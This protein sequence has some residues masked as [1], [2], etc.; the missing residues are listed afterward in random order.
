[1]P[2]LKWCLCTNWNH[3]R[4]M[5][6]GSAIVAEWNVIV[7][8]SPATLKDRVSFHPSESQSPLF[9]KVKNPWLN[10]SQFCSL[11]EKVTWQWSLISCDCDNHS[12]QALPAHRALICICLTSDTNRAWP[13]LALLQ[14]MF[15]ASAAFLLYL[16]SFIKSSCTVSAKLSLNLKC[17]PFTGTCLCATNVHV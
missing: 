5:G 2:I 16:G 1:M 14:E 17:F 15:K 7:S 13:V 11:E 4:S 6:N 8:L 10:T 9:S 3:A 12:A